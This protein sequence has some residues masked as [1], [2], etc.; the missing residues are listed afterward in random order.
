MNPRLR[1]GEI[2]LKGTLAHVA[3][4]ALVLVP[5]LYLANFIKTN[6]NKSY[7]DCLIESTGRTTAPDEEFKNKLRT[8]LAEENPSMDRTWLDH[9]ATRSFS[10]EEAR[11]KIVQSDC[12]A[13][14]AQSI[15]LFP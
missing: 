8:K 4:S 9:S 1:E 14:T 15:P 3:L 6:L 12:I 7:S 5:G 13:K 11:W 2:I 10:K